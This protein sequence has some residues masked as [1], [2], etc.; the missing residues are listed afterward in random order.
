MYVQWYVR[1]QWYLCV[2]ARV[3]ARV[4]TRALLTRS[5]DIVIGAL[6]AQVGQSKQPVMVLFLKVSAPLYCASEG[7]ED[8]CLLLLILFIYRIKW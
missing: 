8:I 3:C 7:H 4:C 6:M 5:L 1:V 2:C